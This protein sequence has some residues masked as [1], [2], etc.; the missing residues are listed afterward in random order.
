MRAEGLR[1]DLERLTGGDA[2]QDLPERRRELGAVE[3]TGRDE[4][5]TKKSGVTL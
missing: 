1:R 5:S 3:L 2:R 4:G